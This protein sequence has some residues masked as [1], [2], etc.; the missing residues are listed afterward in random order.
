MVRCEKE[1]PNSV[2][3]QCLFCTNGCRFGKS[4]YCGKVQYPRAFFIFIK[5][6]YVSCQGSISSRNIYFRLFCKWKYLLV[7]ILYQWVPICINMYLSK[8]QYS[9]PINFFPRIQQVSWQGSILFIRQHLF[10]TIFKQKY[11][12]AFIF[13]QLIKTRK[14]AKLNIPQ[15]HLFYLN[16]TCIVARFNI[17]WQH[18]CLLKY[19]MYRDKVQYLA[20]LFFDYFVS[21]NIY[22]CLFCTNGYRFV[23][24]YIVARFNILHQHFFPKNTTSIVARFN[25]LYPN[26]F[27]FDYF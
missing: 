10:S 24:T 6:Q 14:V 27:I 2:P 5:I 25:T 13:S 18:S 15:Q 19:N 4:M 21:E 26:T 9:P 7:F 3:C 17:L 20:T 23:T 1:G 22:Q 16:T 11:L 12:L 8:A